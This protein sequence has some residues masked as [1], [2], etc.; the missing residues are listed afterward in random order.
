[1]SFENLQKINQSEQAANTKENGIE[2][3]TYNLESGAIIEISSREFKKK[4]KEADSIPESNREKSGVATIFLS[5]WAMGAG[6]ES[7]RI[8]GEAFAESSENSTYAISTR[9][10]MMA[11]KNM[12]YEEAQAVAKFIKDKGIREVILTGY[13]QGGDKAVNVAA[14]LQEDPEMKVGGL[15]L[16][17]STGLYEQTPSALVR[18]FSRD[19]LLDTP[20]TLAKNIVKN[21]EAAKRGIVILTDIIFGVIR[22]M[23]KSKLNYASR[24]KT[25]IKEMAA[26]NP[27]LAKLR[28]PIIL[29]SG[30]KD[31][32]S[33]PEKIIPSHEEEKILEAWE[34]EQE[35][36]EA[37]KFID[38]REEFL[39]KNI[40]PNSPY[41][42]MV[43]PEKLGHH[44]LPI[45][46]SKSVARASLYLLKRFNR[47]ENPI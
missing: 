6:T 40:F 16:M 5:G 19:S 8:F 1:M 42:R 20:K 17:D 36:T 14:I 12:L 39:R 33:S 46:R 35:T 10:E 29:L 21:P 31:L 43:V 38:P 13:S 37:K 2:R 26:V 22:E 18:G 32:V 47:R 30:A 7:A 45:Y 34:R 23:S 28:M 27:R 15:V 3:V 44:G 4:G 25:E 11:D 9:A 41:I 24:L